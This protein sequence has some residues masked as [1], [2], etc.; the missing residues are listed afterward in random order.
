MK[1]INENLLHKF[2]TIEQKSDDPILI[3][4]FYNLSTGKD[5]YLT[6]Y[7]PETNE[8]C[9]FV[10]SYSDAQFETINIK[11]L[12]QTDIQ[13]D[14]SFRRIPL[15]EL[16]KVPHELE[17]NKETTTK[18]KEVEEIKVE[19]KL[20]IEHGYDFFSREN[21]DNEQDFDR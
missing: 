15:S 16:H 18:E 8:V 19:D 14:N 6:K 1:L 3:A 11:D 4:K 20:E 21:D 7:D 5:Y 2:A 12:E 13:Q 17:E 9:A 10:N